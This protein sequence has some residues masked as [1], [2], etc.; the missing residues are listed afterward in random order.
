[1]TMPHVVYWG[2][3]QEILKY[4]E[5]EILDAILKSRDLGR[6]YC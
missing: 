6:D 3:F 1:M 2:S 5:L 4:E